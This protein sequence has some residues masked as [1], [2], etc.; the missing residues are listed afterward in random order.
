[1]LRNN[2]EESIHEI[3]IVNDK[4][5]DSFDYFPRSAI[6]P[7]QIIPLVNELLNNGLEI[8]LKE[9]AIFCA[10][11]SGQKFHSIVDHF[12][13]KNLTNEIKYGQNLHPFF[14]FFFF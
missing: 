2:I 14:F 7:F 4:S 9:I 12:I 8:D 10:S 3:D 13:H 5:I 6:K 11:H 1:M